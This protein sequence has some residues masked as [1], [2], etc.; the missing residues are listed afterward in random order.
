MEK[1]FETGE[2][3]DD[4]VIISM[5]G[6]DPKKIEAPLIFTLG[7]FMYLRQPE[8]KED[9]LKEIRKLAEH[10][11]PVR[12]F[13]AALRDKFGGM[14]A[15]DRIYDSLNKTHKEVVNSLLREMTFRDPITKVMLK[16]DTIESMVDCISKIMVGI[17]P[18]LPE[19]KMYKCSKG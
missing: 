8:E 2:R 17:D 19:G 6:I 1:M 16:Q 15:P 4:R 9:Y 13:E 11:M 7:Y 5:E 10:N 18:Y 12:D 3:L 14:T